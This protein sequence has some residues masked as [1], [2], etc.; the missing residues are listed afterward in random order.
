MLSEKRT[1]LVWT[2]RKHNRARWVM[3]RCNPKVHYFPLT[4]RSEVFYFSY[5]TAFCTFLKWIKERH[6]FYLPI[7]VRFHVVQRPPNEL[8]LC[9]CS[10]TRLVQYRL[11][12]IYRIISLKKT[13]DGKMRMSTISSLRRGIISCA[14]R[15]YRNN[16]NT[17]Y[18]S[19][20]WYPRQSRAL[21][22]CSKYLNATAVTY[23]G[24]CI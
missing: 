13:K 17:T 9:S 14:V 20:V 12:R 19:V 24:D 18:K 15:S 4:A 2:G 11:I 7:V 1:E 6:S 5:I 10:L 22:C 23:A 8:S 3:W 21:F 16:N